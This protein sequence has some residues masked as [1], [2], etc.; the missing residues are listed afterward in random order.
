MKTYLDQLQE[1]QNATILMAMKEPSTG[2][3]ATILD[4]RP[5][6]LYQR[7]LREAMNTHAAGKALSIQRK[8]SND[9]KNS[10]HQEVIQRRAP[11]DK[12]IDTDTLLMHGTSVETFSK[13]KGLAKGFEKT[14]DPSKPSEP[15][16]FSINDKDFS[17]Q[18]P[19]FMR[20]KYQYLKK[21]KTS[22]L[23]LHKFR[24]VSNLDIV[25]WEKWRH[26]REDI[27]RKIYPD[28]HQEF[29]KNK[30]AVSDED[31]ERRAG[32]YAQ[33]KGSHHHLRFNDAKAA[34]EIK[35]YGKDGYE[36][37]QDGKFRK[38]EVVLFQPGLNKLRPIEVD[39]YN[40][41]KTSR[42]KISEIPYTAEHFFE[43][44]NNNSE[45]DK[46]KFKLTAGI[47]P[48]ARNIEKTGD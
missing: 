20:K 11:Q 31:L 23:Y 48:S 30:K 41:K 12:S 35:K 1:Q 5:S 32:R 29:R 18:V 36:V 13:R 19:L 47:D 38:P 21:K 25:S 9:V 22:R 7:K 8:V 37:R 10:A 4:D 27:F 17:I 45:E 44:T 3:R 34:L 28:I 40:V 14:T 46:Y 39:A 24:P 16:F 6:T 26:A 2:G 33:T 15:A 42:T 43:V